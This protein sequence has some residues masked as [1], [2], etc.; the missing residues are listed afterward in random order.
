MKGL[1]YWPCG[2]D[3]CVLIAEFEASC[4][5]HR[6]WNLMNIF[7]NN[8]EGTK[9]CLRNLN[10]LRKNLTIWREYWKIEKWIFGWDQ[11]SFTAM[12]LQYISETWTISKNV[13][14]KI[15]AFQMWYYRKMHRIP[16]VKKKTITDV[17]RRTG[18][19]HPT[20]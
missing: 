13:E 17:L 20:L 6:N 15:K 16:W 3:N 8:I 18:L 19:K 10:L 11:R 4:P 1:S 14:Q 5:L 2:N 12:C 7:I 9:N